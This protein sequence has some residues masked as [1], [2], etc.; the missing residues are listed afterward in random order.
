MWGETVS[1]VLPL[2]KD[3]STVLYL[4][5]VK[6]VEDVTDVIKRGDV[7]VGKYTGQ[8]KV[9]VCEEIEKKILQGNYSVLVATEA[10][11]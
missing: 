4:D 7:N 10:Y 11:I 8:M 1:K 3:Q 5:F 9:P 6:D 2:M